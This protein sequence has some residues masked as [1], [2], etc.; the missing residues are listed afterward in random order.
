MACV[1]SCSEA[2]QVARDDVV[3]AAGSWHISFKELATTKIKAIRVQCRLCLL[4]GD[5]LLPVPLPPEGDP[6]FVG[7]GYFPE[8]N[9]RMFVGFPG[10][11]I[12]LHW[13]ALV[14]KVTP[15]QFG[16]VVDTAT[17]RRDSS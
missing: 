2:E 8:A 15:K 17:V 1:V 10:F 9:R 5:R 13:R 6:R 11:P 3:M 16:H 12:L 7:K 14:E 4:I